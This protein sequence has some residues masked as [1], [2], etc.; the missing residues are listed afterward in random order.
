MCH[1]LGYNPKIGCINQMEMN[2]EKEIT[3]ILKA[4]ALQKT[5]FP[6]NVFGV[7]AFFPKIVH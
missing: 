3:T 7:L 5:Y 2:K 1:R 6:K 4:I